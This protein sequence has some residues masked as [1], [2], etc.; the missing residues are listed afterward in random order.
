MIVAT[1]VALVL[2]AIVMRHL[3]HRSSRVRRSSRYPRSRVFRAAELRELDAHLDRVCAEEV[4]LV[5]DDVER[6]IAGI[7]GHI[8]AISESRHGVALALSDGR[9]L[10]LG[11]VSR[12]S[13]RLLAMRAADDR[14]RPAR[15]ARD[16]L[17]YRLLLRGE[18]G[19]ELE[20]YS[21]VVALAP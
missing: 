16:G 18:A 19:S 1:G 13:L 5:H 10:A 11:R 21:S 9:R 12:S 6:Y 15:V 17:S 8:L 7:V 20:I 2:L 3:T 14:L 4:R